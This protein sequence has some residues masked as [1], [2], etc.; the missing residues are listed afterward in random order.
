MRSQ[1]LDTAPVAATRKQ[2]L[3]GKLDNTRRERL[4]QDEAKLARLLAAARL[5]SRV[6]RSVALPRG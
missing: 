4:Q 2:W 6:A 3:E 1:K 5:A